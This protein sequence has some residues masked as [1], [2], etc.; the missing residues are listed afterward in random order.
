MCVC[1]LNIRCKQY[2]IQIKEEQ[3]RILYDGIFCVENTSVK[4]ERVIKY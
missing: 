1:V 2:S 3:L 4:M